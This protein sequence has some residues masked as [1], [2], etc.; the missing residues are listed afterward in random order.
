MFIFHESSKKRLRLLAD[1]S[2][3]ADSSEDSDIIFQP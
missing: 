3:Q 2:K 1:T